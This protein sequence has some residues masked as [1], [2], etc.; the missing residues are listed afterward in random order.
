MTSYFA[1]LTPESACEA[2]ESAGMSCAPGEV[3][4]ATRDERWAVILPG[5]HIAWFPA[6]E[7]GGRRLTVE[8]RV[9]RLLADRCSFQ[10]PRLLAVSASGFDVRRMVPGRCDPWGLFQRCQTDT[11]LAQ[12]IGRSIGSMLAEQHTAISE[13][14]VTE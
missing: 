14:D 1:Y 2:L 5:E 6:S 13:A 7:S 11:A 10:A 9:L 4:I 12:K 8:R 3:H